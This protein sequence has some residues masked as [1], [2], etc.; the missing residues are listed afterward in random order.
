MSQVTLTKHLNAQRITAGAFLLVIFMALVGARQSP[1][2]KALAGGDRVPILLFGTDAADKSQHTDTLMISVFDPLQNTLSMVSIPRDTHVRIPGYLFNRVNEIFGYH[3]RK[4]KDHDAAANLVKEGVEYI[5][6]S[7]D[8]KVDIPYFVN[9]DYS[10]F[11]NLVNLVGGVWVDVD[12]SMNYDDNAGN[13]HIHFEPG[14]YLLKG[15]DALRYVRFRGHT[16]DRGRIFRQQEF[17][18]NMSKRMANPMV[19]LKFPEMVRALYASVHTNLNFWDVVFFTHAVR[20]LR[21]PN[22]GFYILP[23]QPRGP[24]WQVKREAADRLVGNLF[25]GAKADEGFME[26]VAP[27]EGQITANVWNAS[28]KKGGAY[29]ITKYLRSQG[30]DVQEWGTYPDQQSATRVI[31][32]RGNVKNAQKVANALGVENCHSE[33]NPNALVDVEVVIGRDYDGTA[34]TTP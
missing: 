22:I 21:F 7:E 14:R 5:L 12:Q 33:P 13:L 32:R 4:K 11:K 8:K 16:G 3:M 25:F 29:Q 2:A 27:L 26:P 24:Y 6:S 18:R 31:D 23:G 10:G 28:G 20:R 34:L 9:V 30:I 17:L 15:D 1:I 19:V